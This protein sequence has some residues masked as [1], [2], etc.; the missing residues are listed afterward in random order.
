[1]QPAPEKPKT[2]DPEIKPDATEAPPPPPEPTD[3]SFDG[4]ESNP[5]QA[6]PKRGA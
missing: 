6:G 4:G 2:A 3:A 5:G 1:M